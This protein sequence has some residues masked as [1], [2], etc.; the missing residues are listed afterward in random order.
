VERA[1][2][3]RHAESSLGARGILNGHPAAANPL[4]ETGKAQARRLGELLAGDRIDLA[5]VTSFTRTRQTAELALAGRDV[6]FLAVPE[7]DEIAYGQWEGRPAP[8][9]LE[10]A[11]ASG[12]ALEC[13]GG[14]ESRTT[15]I[16][17]LVRGWRRVLARE[18]E[19]VLVVGHGLAI[20]Y[21]LNALEGGPPAPRLADVPL[22]EPF[23]LSAAE[24]GDA[25][26]RIEGWLAA[27][28]W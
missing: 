14:G 10:W 2:L 24:L 13:P 15:A 22:A 21:V 6:P 11:R 19:T 4:S 1:I 5:V 8:E 20:R 18:E 12:S 17:R 26:D 16:D 28:T 23:R 27:P 7:L 25:V 9:Y 3:A